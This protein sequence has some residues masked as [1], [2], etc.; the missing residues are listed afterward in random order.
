M[1]QAGPW[2]NA[3]FGLTRLCNTKYF[4]LLI[5]IRLFE[6]STKKVFSM[7]MTVN[8]IVCNFNHIQLISNTLVIMQQH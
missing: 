4:I 6:F 2:F 5:H 7:F 8:D 3:F 1:K